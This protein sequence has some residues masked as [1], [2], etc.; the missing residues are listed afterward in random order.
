MF[1]VLRIFLPLSIRIFRGTAK[2]IF[3]LNW[4]DNLLNLWFNLL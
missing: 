1:I 3:W 2:S 4:I